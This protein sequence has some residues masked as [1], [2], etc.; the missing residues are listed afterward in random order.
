MACDQ[1]CGSGS[2]EYGSAYEEWGLIY[3][4]RKKNA[5]TEASERLQIQHVTV[6]IR[7]FSFSFVV[8]VARTRAFFCSLW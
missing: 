4:K 1:Q 6:C 8:V 2:L 3:H 5:V 7:L